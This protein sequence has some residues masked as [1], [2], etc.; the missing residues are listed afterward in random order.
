MIILTMEIK[1]SAK[2]RKNEK[3]SFNYTKIFNKTLGSFLRTGQIK[4]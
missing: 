4:V 2:I 3:L 1:N